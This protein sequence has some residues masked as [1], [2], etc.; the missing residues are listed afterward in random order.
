[1]VAFQEEM[2]ARWDFEVF[3]QE[4][5][6]S[7]RCRQIVDRANRKGRFLSWDYQPIIDAKERYMRNHLD[8]N[9]VEARNRYPKP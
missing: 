2:N 6:L 9:V 1:M 5:K 7:Q 8:L 3:T 4:V